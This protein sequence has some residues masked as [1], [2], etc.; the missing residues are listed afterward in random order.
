MNFSLVVRV[1]G[2]CWFI[3]DVF[4]VVIFNKNMHFPDPCNFLHS[5]LILVSFSM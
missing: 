4:F 3:L 1:N 5:S 2:D